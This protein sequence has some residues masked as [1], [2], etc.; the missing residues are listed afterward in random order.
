MDKQYL[1]NNSVS[2]INSYYVTNKSDFPD[3]PMTKNQVKKWF[4]AYVKSLPNEVTIEESF[5][6]KLD[7][8]RKYI[9]NK[10][11]NITFTSQVIGSVTIDNDVVV[12]DTDEH[13]R[14]TIIA[15]EG[16]TDLVIWQ[17]SVIAAYEAERCVT[18]VDNKVFVK[19]DLSK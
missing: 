10:L 9:T 14:L 19:L 12:I 5:R 17:T 1:L 4:W 18:I 7:S 11:K 6:A 3:Y 2:L 8:H 13:E 16:E 15:P